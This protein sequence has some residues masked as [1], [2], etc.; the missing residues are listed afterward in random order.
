MP[1]FAFTNKDKW[2][3]TEHL[4]TAKKCVDSVWYIARHIFELSKYMHMRDYVEMLRSRFYIS[5]GNILDVFCDVTKQRKRDV[6]SQYDL[7]NEIYYERD[8][9]S[10]HSDMDWRDREFKMLIDLFS[11]MRAQ[12]KC[13]RYVTASV[14]PDC[15]TLD[16]IPFDALCF[17]YVNGISSYNIGLINARK[18]PF[19]KFIYSVYSPSVGKRYSGVK[20]NIVHCVY[21]ALHACD[22]DSMAVFSMN[23]ICFEHGIQSRQDAAV[24]YN[25]VNDSDVWVR[26]DSG[27]YDKIVGLRNAGVIDCCDCPRF[28]NVWSVDF[29]IGICKSLVSFDCFRM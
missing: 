25:V 15:V 13:V 16:F 8:K 1:G 17:S 26:F 21:D 14:L 5:C 3:L 18:Y 20:Y 4:M 28:L 23:G 19:S 12:L 22:D 2:I 11:C 6:R 7:V 9:H 29:L 24:V 27:V 10:A